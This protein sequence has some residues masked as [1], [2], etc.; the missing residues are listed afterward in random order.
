MVL[1]IWNGIHKNVIGLAAMA[2]ASIPMGFSAFAAKKE[3]TDVSAASAKAAVCGY[4][5]VT[6]KI[7]GTK[8]SLSGLKRDKDESLYTVMDD[9]TKITA[10]M[11]EP[12]SGLDGDVE[13]LFVCE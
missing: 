3:N 2:A 4:S 10:T 13:I 1:E 5:V 6:N 12:E 7:T 8:I 11:T 9:G